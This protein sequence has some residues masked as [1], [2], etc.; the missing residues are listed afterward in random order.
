MPSSLSSAL[1]R[2]N[3]NETRLYFAFRTMIAAFLSILIAHAFG[4]EHP[5]WAG[6]TVW[7]C[8]QPIREHLLERGLWRFLGSI[9]GILV[10]IAL[11]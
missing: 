11:I 10:G 4:L 3:I 6:M 9:S 1:Q 7:A 5:Q 2:F 8:S